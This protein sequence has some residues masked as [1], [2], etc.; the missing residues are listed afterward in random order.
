MSFRPIDNFTFSQT[1]SKCVN[2]TKHYVKVQGKRCKLCL[3][4]MA[5]IDTNYCFLENDTVLPHS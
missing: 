3:H 1:I 4:F 2:V 5:L